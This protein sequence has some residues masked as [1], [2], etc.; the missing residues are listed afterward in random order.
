MKK[1]K[2][3][4]SPSTQAQLLRLGQVVSDLFR[5]TLEKEMAEMQFRESRFRFEMVSEEL[6]ALEYER[7]SLLETQ[8]QQKR[9][10]H[11]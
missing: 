1:T 10:N 7:A 2:P 8:E 5:K 11:K 3:S 4:L 6:E 9:R